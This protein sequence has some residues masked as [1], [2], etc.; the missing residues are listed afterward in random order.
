MIFK[1]RRVQQQL[2][3]HGQQQQPPHDWRQQT[4]S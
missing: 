3:Q 2:R 4:H 1:Q